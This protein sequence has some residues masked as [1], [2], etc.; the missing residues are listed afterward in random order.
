VLVLS[1][2]LLIGNQVPDAFGAKP[3]S[4]TVRYNGGG[5]TLSVEDKDGATSFTD[6]CG[7]VAPC[8]AD[9]AVVDGDVIT[10]YSSSGVGPSLE[11]ETRFFIDGSEFFFGNKPDKNNVATPPLHTSCSAPQLL[12]VV[13]TI[14]FPPGMPVTD[15]ITVLSQIGGSGADCT[16]PPDIVGGHGGPIDKTALMVTGA[17]LSASW[18]IPVLISAI[19]IG[20][21]V[22][23]RK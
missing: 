14:P 20:V 2:S 13:G 3:Q 4:I 7:G 10:V 9:F 11:S 17:Q 15:T 5:G 21:F 12:G 18:M 23:T 19:G 6:P 8:A 1:I 16:S 22:V